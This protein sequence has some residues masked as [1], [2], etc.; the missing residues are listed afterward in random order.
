VL[1]PPT[2]F[3]PAPS[4]ASFSLSFASENALNYFIEYHNKLDD[5]SWTLLRTETGNGAVIPITD[6]IG[7]KP[8]RFYRIRVE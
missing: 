3:N 5:P 1:V 8:A 4:S 2:I 6:T 7:L